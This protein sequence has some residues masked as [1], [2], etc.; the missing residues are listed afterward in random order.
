MSVVIPT[1]YK[2]KTTFQERKRFLTLV[3]NAETKEIVVQFG[4]HRM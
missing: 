4:K 3:H 1:S 2:D